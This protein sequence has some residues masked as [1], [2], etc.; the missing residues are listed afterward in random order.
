M[1][2]TRVNTAYAGPARVNPGAPQNVVRSLEDYGLM[3]GV[4]PLAA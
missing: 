1:M 3:V 2:Y 4:L